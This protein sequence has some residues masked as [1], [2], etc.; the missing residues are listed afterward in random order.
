MA[1]RTKMV[2]GSGSG[3][4]VACRRWKSQPGGMYE[5]V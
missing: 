4:G 1:A 3:L 5:Y 2:V